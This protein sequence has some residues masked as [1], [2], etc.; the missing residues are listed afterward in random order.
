MTQFPKL[1]GRF[2]THSELRNTALSSAGPQE[3]GLK[4]LGKC[5]F[6]F[7]LVG[8]KIASN[9]QSFESSI[10]LR[11]FNLGFC[12]LYVLNLDRDPSLI[13]SALS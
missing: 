6:L 4:N 1:H 9:C 2:C 8:Y 13:Y 11:T 3:K 12:V 10:Y 7:C 5:L